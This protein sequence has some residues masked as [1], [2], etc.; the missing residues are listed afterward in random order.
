MQQH[1]L[2]SPPWRRPQIRAPV[3]FAARFPP[4][5]GQHPAELGVT[6]AAFDFCHQ[7][8]EHPSIG[9]PA[10]GAAFAHPAVVDE[11]EIE[12]ADRRRLLEHSG[13]QLAGDIPSRLPARCGIEGISGHQDADRSPALHAACG[14]DGCQ[15]ERRNVSNRCEGAV[16]D[17]SVDH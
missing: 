8:G 7:V 6:G 1:Q 2:A 5:H 3:P 14:F 16:S 10:R 11:L 17:Q 13:L 9:D 15:S 4:A 12:S